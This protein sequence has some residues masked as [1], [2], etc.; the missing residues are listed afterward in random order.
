MQILAAFVRPGAKF[1]PIRPIEAQPKR[2]VSSGL[3]AGATVNC[4]ESRRGSESN[5]FTS[6]PANGDTGTESEI[7]PHV[8][9]SHSV[10]RP[11]C[12]ARPSS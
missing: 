9:V 11:G 2:N 6:V 5:K 10:G 4:K 8:S 7:A 1:A 12:L 3:T